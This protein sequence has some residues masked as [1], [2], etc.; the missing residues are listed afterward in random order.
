ML[1]GTLRTRRLAAVGLFAVV[2][3]V[4]AGGARAGLEDELGRSEVRVLSAPY[5]LSPGVTVT[6][7]ALP[8]RLERLGY[9]RIHDRPERPGEFFW[10]LDRFWIYR[11]AHDYDGERVEARLLGLELSREDGTVLGVIDAD[12]RPV[13]A[14][15]EGVWLE[16]EVLAESLTERRA[17]RRPIELAQLPEHVWRPVLAAEDSRFFEHSGLDARGIARAL[18]ANA[19]AGKVVQ[20]GSTITQQLI[21]SRDLTPKRSFGR[22]LS[23][24]VR[25]LEVEAEYDKEEILQAYLNHV[26]FGHL[27]GVGIYGLGAAARAYFSKAAAD[28]DLAQAAVLAAMIQGPNRLSLVRH[29]QAARERQVW[30]LGRMEE[31]G[32]ATAGEVAAARGKTL[33]PLALSPP[34]PRGDRQ[35]IAWV[36]EV[37]RL[38]APDRFEEGR[39]FLVE[40]AFDAALQDAA[41]EVVETHLADLRRE[42]PR[43]KN[44]PLSAAVVTLDARTGEVLVHVAGDPA[45][46]DDAFDRVRQ[47]RRQPGSAIKPLVLLEAFGDCNDDPLYPARRIEDGPIT[48]E[49]E[50]GP[51]QPT[52]FSPTFRGTVTLRDALVASL[53]TPFVRVARHCGFEPTA[54]RIRRAGVPLPEPAPPAFVLGAVET[55][56]LA[57][58]RSFAVFPNLGERVRAVPVRRIARPGGSL[59]A[60]GRSG[61][62]RVVDA[63]SAYLV[64]DLLR[65]AVARGT[66]QAAALEGFT[67]WGKTGTSDERRDAWFVGGIGELLTAVWVGVDDGTPLGLTGSDAAAP[68]WHDVM[69]RVAPS[70]PATAIERPV[71][72]TTA[73]VQD[74]TGLR[75][76]PHRPGSHEDLFRRGAEPLHRRLL[77]ADEPVPVLR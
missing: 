17:R 15:G 64:L 29:P 50:S 73:W 23:E 3:M 61:R 68:L 21:K 32:W 9:Q 57:M 58:A 14:G 33:P 5:P 13:A 39:G 45:D 60:H 12:Q 75:V 25:T 63:A 6:G 10:G 77:R 59:V 20:G 74:D 43:L 11:R 46:P 49:L 7:A 8:E 36:A 44:L 37:V 52:N 34:A 30:V 16:P 66:G 56:P 71:R 47:A 35:L 26:Y 18:L 54:L 4:P 69:A 1:R 65:D 53:N 67:A 38:E 40:T 51:W 31:L 28:L 41:T 76:R 72:V 42:H 19:R 48:L 22:K 27:D 62:R 24:A 70:R 2:V 55:T